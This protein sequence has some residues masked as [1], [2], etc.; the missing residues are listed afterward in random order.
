MAK[1]KTER[2]IQGSLYFVEINGRSELVCFSNMVNYI[3][4]DKWYESRK[5]D[6]IK[7]AE[8]IFITAA[9]IIMS[10]IREMNYDDLVYPTHDDIVLPEKQNYFMPSSPCKFLEVLV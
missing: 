6:K 9:K 10:E 2:K 8:R 3:I 4:N 5:S 7:E 1:N